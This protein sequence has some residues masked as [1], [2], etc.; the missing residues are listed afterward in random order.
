M[1]RLAL[2]ALLSAASVPTLAQPAPP[3]VMTIEP[4]DAEA[5][6]DIVDSTIPPRYNAA[7]IRWYQGLL[8]RYQQK[9]QA[10]QAARAPKTPEEVQRD[11]D[12]VQKATEGNR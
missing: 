5:F 6:K 11:K 12:A 10:L 9:Q 1:K 7:L 8:Q 2:V 3:P 4:A